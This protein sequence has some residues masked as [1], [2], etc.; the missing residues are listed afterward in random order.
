[1]NTTQYRNFCLFF[2]LLLTTVSCDYIYDDLPD[3]LHTLRFVHVHNMKFADAFAHEM[4]C[5]E[6]T[7]KVQLYIYDEEGRF[8][9]TRLIEGEELKKNQ[10]DVSNLNPG[11]YR[12]LA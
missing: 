4:D 9:S 1:M 6:T 5:Q 11:T 10:I 7:K 2:L 12:L 3:C 8:F